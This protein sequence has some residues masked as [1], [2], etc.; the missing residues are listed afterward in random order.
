MTEESPVFLATLSSRLELGG[1]H[2]RLRIAWAL[3]AFG[4]GEYHI[5]ARR[6]NQRLGEARVE[7]TDGVDARVEI[8]IEA[9]R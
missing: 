1:C 3:S 4:P 7:V 2:G 8:E 6:E 9:G 5:I